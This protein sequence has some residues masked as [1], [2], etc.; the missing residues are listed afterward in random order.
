M[1]IN[2]C[3]AHQRNSSLHQM[4]TNTD[5]QLVLNTRYDRG[6]EEITSKRVSKRNKLG[7][8]IFKLESVRIDFNRFAGF[9]Y[10]ES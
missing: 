8:A 6:K 10:K 2:Q 5:P 3:L 4:G 9:C 7:M 1:P